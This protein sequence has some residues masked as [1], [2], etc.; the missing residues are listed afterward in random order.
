MNKPLRV[1]QIIIPDRAFEFYGRFNSVY[2]KT[3]DK[4][5]TGVVQRNKKDCRYPRLIYL[6]RRGLKKSK[7]HDIGEKRI[8]EAFKKNGYSIISP[9]KLSFNDQVM[10]YHNAEVIASL[11]GT[12]SHNI[13]FTSD[14]T[15]MVILN[16]AT[17]INYPQIGLNNLFDRRIIYIDV[18]NRI[19]EKQPV[20]LGIGPFWVECN[21]NLL[22]WFEDM[23]YPY[24]RDNWPKALRSL[25]RIV[26]YL[27]WKFL[28]G[29]IIVHDVLS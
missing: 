17:D 4:V 10:L 21:G 1:R 9:E 24:H 22:R 15:K 3:I 6:T 25:E 18:Y 16:R 28:R 29:I 12:L 5:V 19:E 20:S 23:G 8:E 27:R 13:V 14:K 26:N 2:A 7:W 11:S